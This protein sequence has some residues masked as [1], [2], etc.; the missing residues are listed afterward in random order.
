MTIQNMILTSKPSL[1][2]GLF[3]SLICSL[4]VIQAADSVSPPQTSSV[5]LENAVWE[6][7]TDRSG[8]AAL[9]LSEDGQTLWVGTTAGLEQRHPETGE[10]K[11]IFTHLDGLPN[12]AISALANDG[13]GGIWVGTD[14]T[15]LTSLNNIAASSGLA[16]YH[17]DGTWAIFNTHNAALPSDN[18]LSL[19]VDNRHGIWVG[20]TKGLAYRHPDGTWQRFEEEQSELPKDKIYWA[21]SLVGDNQGGIWMGAW[22]GKSTLLAHREANGTWEIF[23]SDKAQLPESYITS[24]LGDGKGGL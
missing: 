19:H 4:S 24:L 11:R 7:F 5:S 14:N 10:V 20:T 18:I 16:H 6:V 3:S 23:N 22:M 13:Q 17:S 21:T 1:L 9:L 8:I 2:L 15:D 12:N